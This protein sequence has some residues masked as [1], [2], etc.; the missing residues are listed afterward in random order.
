MTE[1]KKT[2]AASTRTAVAPEKKT[3]SKFSVEEI[4]RTPKAFNVSTYIIAGALHGRGEEFT[5]NEVAQLTKEF[6]KQEVK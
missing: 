2:K 5:K 3:E 6:L 4:L 1:Q